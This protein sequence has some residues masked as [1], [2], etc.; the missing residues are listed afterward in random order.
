LLMLFLIGWHPD[1]PHKA[2][3]APQP[4]ATQAVQ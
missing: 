2:T 3:E 1:A 4:S